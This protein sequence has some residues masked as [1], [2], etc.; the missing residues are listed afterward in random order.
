VLNPASRVKGKQTSSIL[1][2]LARAASTSLELEAVL[3]PRMP[4]LQ[5]RE[6]QQGTIDAEENEDIEL[7]ATYDDTPLDQ[8]GTF[9][10]SENVAEEEQTL[11]ST[12]GFLRVAREAQDA[13]MKQP[14]AISTNFQENLLAESRKRKGET[15]D[16]AKIGQPSKSVHFPAVGKRARLEDENR[17]AGPSSQVYTTPFAPVYSDRPGNIDSATI[18]PLVTLEVSASVGR[19]I[20]VENDSDDSFEIPPIILDSDSGD[21]DEESDDDDVMGVG[22]PGQGQEEE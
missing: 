11:E 7:A 20:E 13:S 15:E 3:R 4:I 8:Q 16:S 9:P 14:E 17:D 5:Q 12:Q 2:F 21:D 22:Q 18:E 1:P 19:R 6:G 10:A